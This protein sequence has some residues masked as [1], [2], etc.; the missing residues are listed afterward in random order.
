MFDDVQSLIDAVPRTVLENI[1]FRMDFHTMLAKDKKLQKV[2]WN[3]C[4][5]DLQVLFDTTFW[6][7]NPRKPWGKQNQP[8]ILRPQQIPVVHRI[9]ENIR[10]GRDTGINKTRDEGASEICTKIF[11]AWV[12]LYE[13]VSFILGSDKKEDVDNIGNDYT[14][15]AKV[16]NVFQHLPSW[17]DFKYQSNGG[18]IKRKDMLLRVGRNNSA[19]IGETTNE[20]FSAGSRATAMVLD[21]FGRIHKSVADSIEGTVHAVT[22]CVIYSSTHWLGQNHTFN[23]C[24]N[25]TTTDTVELLWYQNPEKAE[26]LYESPAKG[27]I[28]LVD[29][30]YYQKK[31]SGLIG[32]LDENN[33]FEL[34]SVPEEYKEK[35]IADGK[36][37]PVIICRSPWHDYKEAQSKGNKRDFYCNVW[38]TPLGSADTVFDPFVLHKIKTNEVRPPNFSG[39]VVFDFNSDDNIVNCEFVPN[40]GERRL[41]WWGNLVNYNENGKP[42]FRPDQRHNY[43][44][45]IDPGQGLG[46]SNSV[47]YLYDVNTHELVGEWVCAYTKPEAFA[48]MCVAIA[49]WCGGVEPT[50][51][52]WERNGGHGTAFTERIKYLGYWHC[53]TMTVEDEKTRKKKDKLGFFSNTERKAALLLEFGIALGY[54]LGGNKRY[55]CAFIYSIELVE[56]LFDYV[57]VGEGKE[58]R[59]SSKADLSSGA[60]ERHGDRAIAAAL[61]ILGTRDQIPGEDYEQKHAP[62]GSF[63]YYRQEEERKQKEDEQTKKKYLF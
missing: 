36:E 61:C 27:R 34:E 52:I 11:S 19:I 49:Y 15:F 13:R 55:V 33:E 58:I 51:L 28:K 17:M 20:N 14:L 40:L 39:E 43:I 60:Y 47:A 50:F 16:D 9:N 63:E 25:K 30:P 26:G 35:F 29:M 6:T 4:R 53:Y 3:F 56:E 18:C 2:F 48:D 57:F 7:L 42:D 8:F 12:M 44:M 54:A 32:H 22:N 1:E 21:E 37:D 5:E 38:A 23:V 41:Q 24:L 46:S 59:T 31:M 45:G 62:A 10:T